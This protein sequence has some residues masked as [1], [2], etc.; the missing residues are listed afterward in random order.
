MLVPSPW[1]ITNDLGDYRNRFSGM[2][3]T[4]MGDDSSLIN[5][6]NN[7]RKKIILSNIGVW[8]CQS[9]RTKID[10]YAEIVETNFVFVETAI[11]CLKCKHRVPNSCHC[12]P[13]SIS[14]YPCLSPLFYKPHNFYYDKIVYDKRDECLSRWT[15]FTRALKLI[16]LID[17]VKKRIL[18]FIALSFI[19]DFDWVYQSIHG[20]R[21]KVF[22]L[23]LVK[24]HFS[25]LYKEL[26]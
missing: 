3:I 11:T 14:L 10:V 24:E 26:E 15:F 18:I 22:S 7:G 25:Y 12:G 20:S 9:A 5:F 16:N 13:S 19:N 2:M 21:R 8:D 23:F 17:D 1:Y 4:T 6:K